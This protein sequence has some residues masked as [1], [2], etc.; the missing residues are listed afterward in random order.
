[1]RIRQSARTVL[2]AV[3]MSVLLGLTGSIAANPAPSPPRPES[4]QE[5]WARYDKRDWA[6]ALDEARRLVERARANSREPMQLADALTLLGNAQLSSGDRVNAEAS[7]REALQITESQGA[8]AGLAAVDPL[9]G[10]GYSLA[11]LE[12]HDEAVPYLERA[13]LIIRRSS[14]L[15]DPSQQS[16]LRQ[17]AT[18]LTRTGRAVDGQ[19][20]MLYL[21]RVGERTY[22]ERDPR[23]SPVL[24][25]VGDWYVDL[26]N[27][28]LGRD[29]YRDAL[30]I[31]ERKLGKD[32]PAL[33]L[34]LRA[35]ARSYIQEVYFLTQGF[36][37]LENRNQM[38]T[39]SPLESK[40]INPKYI[41]SDGE[42]A[43]QRAL[44][45]L[46]SH[47]DTPP[48]VLTDTLIQLGDWYQVK[49]QPEK[50]LPYYRRAAALVANDKAAAAEVAV[51]PLSFPVRVY[52]P[53][54]PLAM[55]NRQLA[56]PEIEEKFVSVEFTV[57]GS[58][59][60]QDAKVIEQ[61]GTQRQ[62]SQA[63]E[64]IR[65]ARYRPKF[66]NGEPVETQGVVNREV[67]KIRKQD[68]DES[69]S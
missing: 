21:Q 53:M 30:E 12:R 7:Y 69:K 38:D 20:Q 58:G 60:V 65:A 48:A 18:S 61:N 37:P 29:R 57:T 2:R 62:A 10:L 33:V 23:M 3:T 11:L 54:P 40:G 42:R 67:F 39:L 68:D 59:D 4:Q 9:R 5:F 63:L 1:M 49:H 19:K 51:A 13:V 17:L 28:L 15:F 44:A 46:E 22:G 31:V 27:F 52:Y 25:V 35:L 45:I 34:P 16:L 50:A 36:Q 8:G 47:P 32:D 14:G 64:A 41:S 24:C 6:A 26:G 66:V 55:R 56:A 43:L